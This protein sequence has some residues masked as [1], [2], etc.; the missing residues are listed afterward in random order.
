MVVM[1]LKYN[2]KR[3]F[4]MICGLIPSSNPDVYNILTNAVSKNEI[5]ELPRW[6]KPPSC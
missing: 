6:H 5:L 3:R 4:G 1:N 2:K